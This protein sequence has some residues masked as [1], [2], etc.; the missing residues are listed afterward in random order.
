MTSST[1]RRHVAS[2]WR[3]AVGGALSG[4]LAGLLVF[5]PAQWLAAALGQVSAGRLLLANARGTV[6]DGTAQLMLTGGAGS[7]DAAALP[8]AVHW[9]LR[10]GMGE[11]LVSV[12][13]TC[14]TPQP[15]R[16]QL[17]PRWGGVTL[18]LADGQSAWPARLLTGLGTPWNTVQ[19]AG[20]LAL[21]SQ[22]LQ[23]DLIDRRLAIAGQARLDALDLSSRL[24]TLRPL[25]S[26]SLTLRGGTDPELELETLRGSLLLSGRGRWVGS[27]LH[28]D[29]EARAAPER[30]EA[31]SNLLNIIGRRNGAQSIISLG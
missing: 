29:G 26:Y 23:L 25:G 1:N 11:L 3:W 21:S 20:Q 5:A 22:G 19:P 28:F 6:W 10:L 2:P 30:E 18:V 15:L 8:G 12:R 4:L 31:L 9:Q 24:S 7:H 16:L 17:R 27:R 13:A 14:C